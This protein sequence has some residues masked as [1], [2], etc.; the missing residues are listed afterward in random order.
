MVR[1]RDIAVSLCI[2]LGVI[3]CNRSEKEQ[4][5]SDQPK[6]GNLAP[7]RNGGQSA[8]QL[9]QAMNFGLHIL[10]VPADNVGQ[11]ENFWKILSPKPL[12]FNSS[13]AFKANSFLVGFGQIE[14]WD[15]VH[16]L[17]YK[18]GGQTMATASLML[19]DDQSQDL[20]VTGL[21]R[22]QTV[23]FVSGDLT[24]QRASIGPGILALRIKAT[25]IPDIRGA[26]TMVA[27][28]VFALPETSSIPELAARGKLREF[29]FIT[30]AFGLKMSPG[31]FVVL[32]PKTYVGDLSTLSSVFF[33]KPEGSVFFS[34]A[35]R[36][37][38]QRKPSVRLFLLVCIRIDH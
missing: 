12:R 37:P 1:A 21:N 17:L 13:E 28:P 35:E 24:P 19:A 7:S 16:D 23:S 9:L 38:P 34:P 2:V 18:A 6:I 31:D 30:A 27:H 10:E 8:A 4:P 11:L 5:A 29:P 15:K 22:R 33:S 25:K 36:K 32:G 3:G 26:C 20:A 14:L